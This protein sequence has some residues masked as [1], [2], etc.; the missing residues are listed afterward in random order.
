[1][2][3]TALA[4]TAFAALAAAKRGCRHDHKNPGWGWYWVVQGDNL[5]AI[6]KD[7]G[8]DAKAIQDRN[9]IPDVYRMG[10]GFTIYVKCP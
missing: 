9:K 1:M 6:A 7:L 10:Y 8:D 5:N 3:F 4:V 2:R